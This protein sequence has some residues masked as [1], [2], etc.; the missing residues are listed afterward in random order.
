MSCMY[1]CGHICTFHTSK[2]SYINVLTTHTHH[3]STHTCINMVYIICKSPLEV[4]FLL[5]VMHTTYF[6]STK[7]LRC[8]IHDYMYACTCMSCTIINTCTDVITILFS[9]LL[10]NCTMPSR[11]QQLPFLQHRERNRYYNRARHERKHNTVKC[12]RH[13]TTLHRC[14]D[15]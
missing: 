7:H 5:H 2:I 3:L 15:Q 9:K 1:I 8:I 4:P 6:T 14:I 12:A 13:N 10:L 11:T